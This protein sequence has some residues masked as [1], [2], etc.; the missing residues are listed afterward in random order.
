VLRMNPLCAVSAILLMSAT[1]L[2]AAVELD[3]RTAAEATVRSYEHAC[4]QFD[5]TTANSLLM[6]DARW[7]EDSYPEPAKFTGHGWSE[8]WEEMK[9]AKVQLHYQI[10][11][12]QTH[13]RGDAAWITLSLD[14]VAKADTAEAIK[15]NGNVREWH[16]TFVES[17]VLVKHGGEWK[18]ALGHTSLVPAGKAPTGEK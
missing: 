3:E 18:V 1:D 9:R 10:R 7:I 13:I 5:F 2:Q 12:L 8:H 15:A 6:P 14:T 11:D 4:E 17:Y 16:G